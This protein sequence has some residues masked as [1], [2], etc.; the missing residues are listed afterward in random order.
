M[1]VMRK[2]LKVLVTIVSFIS[3]NR[4]AK[5]TPET[6]QK[7]VQDFKDLSER[8][9]AYLTLLSEQIKEMHQEV[10]LLN[11]QLNEALAMTCT[12]K[13]KERRVL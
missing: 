5:N 8:H 7:E 1:N 3:G 11:Q 13:C 6:E 4:L 10:A 9:Y 2:I 12:K